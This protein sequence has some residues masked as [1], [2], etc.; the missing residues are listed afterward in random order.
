MPQTATSAAR[1]YYEGRHGPRTP[2]RR[3]EVPT[4]CAAFPKELIFTPQRWLEA[5]YNLTRYTIM[6]SGGH[7][8]AGEV[9]ELFVGDV[10]AFF[11]DLRAG[12]R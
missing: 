7:F 8:A 1:Y 5:G 9:P 11:R 4:A 6:P 2:P 10:R 12:G 3:V